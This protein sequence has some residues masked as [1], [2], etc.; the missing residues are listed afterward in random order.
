MLIMRIDEGV[1][2]C[3]SSNSF[4]LRIALHND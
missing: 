4:I 2:F 1:I 3:V